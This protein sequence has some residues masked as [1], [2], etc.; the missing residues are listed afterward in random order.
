MNSSTVGFNFGYILIRKSLT[1]LG[2]FDF[3]FTYWILKLISPSLLEFFTH[4]GG[5]N[6]GWRG[7]FGSKG[8]GWEYFGGRLRHF[9]GPS[10]G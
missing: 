9:W 5:F 8:F 4:T 7:I 1:L 2:G 10:L 3:P 6:M